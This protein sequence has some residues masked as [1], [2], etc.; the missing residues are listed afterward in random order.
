ML[1][2]PC[3]GGAATRSTRPLLLL[4]VLNGLVATRRRAP[5]AEEA[6]WWPGTR[7]P[8][9][10]TYSRPNASNSAYVMRPEGHLWLRSEPAAVATARLNGVGR[11]AAAHGWSQRQDRRHAIT[12][13]DL[14]K[15]VARMRGRDIRA[16][17]KAISD[18]YASGKESAVGARQ[19]IR[20]LLL[21]PKSA[22]HR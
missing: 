14:E 9:V 1:H 13:A 8:R 10:K 11:S 4:R 20:Q 17:V 16:T 5:V 22:G 19:A 2:K 21:P 7:P 3:C 12:P 15:D 6:S 18:Y